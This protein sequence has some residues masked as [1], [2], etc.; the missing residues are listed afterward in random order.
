MEEVAVEKWNRVDDDDAD[1]V[2]AKIKRKGKEQKSKKTNQ[3]LVY[4]T[5][6]Y[7]I[8]ISNQKYKKNIFV[9][10]IFMNLLN[11]VVFFGQRIKQL[12]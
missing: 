9:F 5:S 7:N 4:S 1:S 8:T 12:S 3:I 2:A 6:E 11:L 10:I